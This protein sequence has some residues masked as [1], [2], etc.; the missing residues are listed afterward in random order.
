MP[1]IQ[2]VVYRKLFV[3][4]RGKKE[5]NTRFD[6]LLICFSDKQTHISKQKNQSEY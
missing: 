2:T 1:R 5:G 6:F 4:E 3:I